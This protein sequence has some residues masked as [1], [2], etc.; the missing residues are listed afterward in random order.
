MELILAL[1]LGAAFGFAL[2]RVGA[3]N[4]NY[5]INMLRLTDLHLMRTIIMAIGTASVLLFGGL[6]LGLVDPGHMDIKTAYIGVVIG[7]GLLGLGFAI[8]GYC[9]GTGFAAMAA[10]RR[11]AVAFV[12]GGLVGAFAYAL[13]YAQ[14]KTTGVLEKLWGGD[15]TLAQMSKL[16]T[17]ALITSLPGEWVGLVLGVVFMAIAWRLPARV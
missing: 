16:D 17:P 5:I 11:D 4:P 6:I 7:G 2:D 13:S 10:G 15:V 1:V 8:A 9:P 3:T 14:V 12:L